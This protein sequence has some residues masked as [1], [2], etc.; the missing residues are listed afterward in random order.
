MWLRLC[1]KIK[2]KKGLIIWNN[3]FIKDQNILE[4]GHKFLIFIFFSLNQDLSISLFHIATKLD[5]LFLKVYLWKMQIILIYKVFYIILWEMQPQK[6]S[7]LV[8]YLYYL[9][10]NEFVKILSKNEK[11]VLQSMFKFCHRWYS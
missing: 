2:N 8:K 9:Y 7:L 4:R 5:G 11:Y 6:I 3:Y 1:W 10:E